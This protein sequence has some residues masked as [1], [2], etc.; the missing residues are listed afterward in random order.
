M[1]RVRLPLLG[2]AG[3]LVALGWCLAGL[4]HTGALLYAA[5]VVILVSVVAHGAEAP[6]DE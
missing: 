1:I 6:P 3:V 5:G 2:W 4:V